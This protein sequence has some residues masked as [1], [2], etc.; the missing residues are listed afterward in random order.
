M[1]N[2]LIWKYVFV[3][4]MFL[5]VSKFSKFQIFS[6]I[7]LWFETIFQGLRPL[8]PL[9]GLQRPPRPATVYRKVAYDSFLPY[10]CSF[11]VVFTLPVIFM[12]TRGSGNP[13]ITSKCY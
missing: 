12:L 6:Q 1:S 13:T 5:F 10:D 2:G 7:I 8:E 3:F 9:G 4:S 11:D